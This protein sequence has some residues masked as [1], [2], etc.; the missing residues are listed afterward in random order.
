MALVFYYKDLLEKVAMQRTQAILSFFFV[1]RRTQLNAVHAQ[2][3]GK[4]R[5]IAFGETCWFLTIKSL[6]L[7]EIW[8]KNS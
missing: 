5:Q 8:Q 6:E 4:L 7:H 3:L 2:L 1:T